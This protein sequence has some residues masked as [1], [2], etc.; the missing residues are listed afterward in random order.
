[1][2]ARKQKPL[3]IV[4]VILGQWAAQYMM[5]G[6]TQVIFNAAYQSVYYICNDA[7]RVPGLTPQ[8][9]TDNFLVKVKVYQFICD[10][11]W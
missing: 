11:P 10:G 6:V 9:A 2:H 5:Y 7:T 3:S 1:M 8:G 4:F